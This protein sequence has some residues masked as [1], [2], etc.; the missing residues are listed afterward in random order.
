MSTDIGAMTV[1]LAKT[2]QSMDEGQT[3][4]KDFG[5]KN[6]GADKLAAGYVVQRSA[7]ANFFVTARRDLGGKSYKCSTTTN[8]ANRQATV[9]SACKPLRVAK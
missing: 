7:G 3:D 1:E 9:V 4:A 5:P 8:S 6:L 2:P